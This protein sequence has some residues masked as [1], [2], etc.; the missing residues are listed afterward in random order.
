MTLFNPNED[1]YSEIL[2]G[3]VNE[4]MEAARAAMRYHVARYEDPGFV[5][6]SDL[7]SLLSLF[8]STIRTIYPKS[9]AKSSR[10]RKRALHRKPGPR[11]EKVPVQQD[12]DSTPRATLGILYEWLGEH[13]L[14]SGPGY[15][16]GTR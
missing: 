6:D 10:R 5:S 12:K 2:L 8:P 3:T 9:V 14:L 16:S 4:D 13:G 11:R 15:Y 1:T 7:D